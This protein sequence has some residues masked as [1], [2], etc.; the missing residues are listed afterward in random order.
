M[1]EQE[2]NKK[3]PIGSRVNYHPVINQPEHFEV[4]TSSTAWRTTSGDIVVRIKGRSS[5]VSIEAIRPIEAELEARDIEIGEALQH[6]R[7]MGSTYFCANCGH[8]ANP[9]HCGTCGLDNPP[10]Q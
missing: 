7:A 3:Y 5:Y 6:P 8:A 1:S 2:F 4:E 10:R 9:V